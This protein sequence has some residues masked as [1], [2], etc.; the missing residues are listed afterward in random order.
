MIDD[1]G[2]PPC[3]DASH[4]P[5]RQC[6]TVHLPAPIAVEPP[7]QI[8]R[9]ALL[10]SAAIAGA[11]LAMAPLLNRA[12]AAEPAEPPD[13]F[14]DKIVLAPGGPGNPGTPE[15]PPIKLRINGND[16]EVR[17]DVRTTLLDTLRD[18]LGLTGTK[19]GCDH[20]Q[21]GACTVLMDGR[22]VNS[23]LILTAMAQG[24]EITTI[25]G[26]A[27]SGPAGELHPLQTAFI[28]R[29]AFECGFCTPGQICS[30]VGLIHEGH[31][32]TDADIRGQMS[33][34]ICRCGAY[35]N[36]VD[37]VRDVMTKTA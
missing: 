19:R 37:A 3:E 26:L 7:R 11:G 2:D 28:D 4:V 33:G 34:N 27:P 35:S 22:R 10:E 29:D 36:I 31:A 20:G 23:C 32:Q 21:C 14:H 15:T 1:T 5:Q 18:Q 13:T 8:S 9:R 30:A 17:A 12:D 6:E 25:E 16:Y 24:H